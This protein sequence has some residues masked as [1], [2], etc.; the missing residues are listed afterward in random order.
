MENNCVQ[1]STEQLERVAVYSNYVRICNSNEDNA[2]NVFSGSGI[3]NVSEV[4]GG[5]RD[6]QAG[7][8]R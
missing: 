5:T 4:G 1:N 6:L 3:L 2:N 7:S 8:L